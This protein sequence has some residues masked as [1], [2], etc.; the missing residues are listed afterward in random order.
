MRIGAEFA[1]GFA[2]QLDAVAQCEVLLEKLLHRPIEA[3]NERG[4]AVSWI[5]FPV[6]HFRDERANLLPLFPNKERR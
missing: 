4:G 1:Y 6:S 5:A 2:L 3:A